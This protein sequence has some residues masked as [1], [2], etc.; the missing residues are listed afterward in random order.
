MMIVPALPLNLSL[1]VLVA[2]AV[3]VMAN[4]VVIIPFAPIEF[5]GTLM[6]GMNISPVS[7]VNAPGPVVTNADGEHLRSN[8]QVRD[9]DGYGHAADCCFV[10][11]HGPSWTTGRPGR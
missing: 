11:Q 3:D 10:D 6:L 4:N 5:A 7:G 9:V 8:H 1:K 2:V